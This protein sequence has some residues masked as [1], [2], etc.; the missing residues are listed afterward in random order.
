MNILVVSEGAYP[1]TL[2]GSQT[3]IYETS[4]RLAA[5]GHHVHLLTSSEDASRPA[6]EKLSGVELSRY[7]QLTKSRVGDLL[8]LPFALLPAFMKLTRRTGFDAVFLHHAPSGFL[9]SFFFHRAFPLIH[10]FH[11]PWHREFEIR[12]S[13]S[14]HGPKGVVEFISRV[15]KK[16]HGILLGRSKLILVQSEY[17]KHQVLEM[18]PDLDPARVRIAASGVDLKL[19]S[20]SENREELRKRLGVNANRFILLTVRRLVPRT[21]VDELIQAMPEILSK[22]CDVG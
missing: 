1:E 13:Y 2:G 5:R 6:D 20:P 16:I 9:I 8:I 10:Y 22:D 3:V 11:A 17:M 7:F 18:K 19:F 15:L 14:Y 4:R 12:W 21:G